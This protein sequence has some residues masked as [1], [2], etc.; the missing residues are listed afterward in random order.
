MTAPSGSELQYLWGFENSFGIWDPAL[1]ENTLAVKS[2]SG[3]MGQ[4]TY[5]RVANMHRSRQTMKGKKSRVDFNMKIENE[6][7][8]DDLPRIFAHFMRK[9]PT[10]TNPSGSAFQWVNVPF[11]AGDAANSR[12]LDSIF[13]EAHDGDGHPVLVS[14]IKIAEIAMKASAGKMVGLSLSQ[15]G[16]RDTFSSDL[17]PDV[18]N[19]GTYVGTP[20]IRG[21]WDQ[22]KIDDLEI[23]VSGA[24]AG[25][26]DG[27]IQATTGATAYGSVEIDIEFGK[28]YA[29]KMSSDGTRLGLNASDELEI[30]FPAAAG[31]LAVA[32]TWTGSAQRTAATPSYSTR[33]VLHAAGARFY[34]GSDEYDTKDFEIKLTNPTA[35]SFANGSLYAR[36]QQPNGRISAT[37]SLNRDREDREFLKRIIS[38]EAFAAQI[39]VT[40]NNITGA[41]DEL[42]Q[43][44]F[45]NCQVTGN[46]RNTTTENVLPE[47]VDIMAH[48]AGSTDIFQSTIVCGVATVV[49]P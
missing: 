24:A 42:L 9:D 26:F 3:M 38:G 11:E 12:Y 7:T 41:Y 30:C 4:I 27:T 43:L 14:G 36:A 29:L 31:T 8:I 2:V 6:P 40:G 37:I 45:S 28:W 39:K 46:D 20:I 32:D 22:A 13:A 5:E 48:R 15:F 47:K 1:L 33:D 34:L 23:T 16:S 21:H 44:D 10:I 49:N 35:P 18:G 17:T 25:D 19:T